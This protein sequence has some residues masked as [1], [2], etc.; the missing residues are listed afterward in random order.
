MKT[1]LTEALIHAAIDWSLQ[2][3]DFA[4]DG[5]LRD[6]YIENATI[7]D[8]KLVVDIIQRGDYG[9]RLQRGGGDVAMPDNFESLFDTED[10]HFLRFRVSGVGLDCHFFAPGEIEFSFGPD[11]V[12]EDKLH[13]LLA[14]MI[15]LGDATDKAVIMTPENCEESPIFRYAP[16]EHQLRWLAPSDRNR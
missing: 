13:G 2:K 10:R 7:D 16:S 6:I 8:W 3:A 11:E 5:S 14:F 1:D 15:D 12:T 4:A 9:A